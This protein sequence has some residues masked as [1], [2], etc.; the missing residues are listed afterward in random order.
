MLLR[1]GHTFNVLELILLSPKASAPKRFFP[2][3]AKHKR[4]MVLMVL[5]GPLEKLTGAVY[6]VV[7]R[8]QREDGQLDRIVR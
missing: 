5:M 1:I 7:V 2:L 8:R 3:A 4:V 6:L